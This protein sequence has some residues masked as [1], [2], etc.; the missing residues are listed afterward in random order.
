MF[1]LK[2][3]EGLSTS[4]AFAAL[5]ER[6]RS[7]LMCVAASMRSGSASLAGL[8][9]RFGDGAAEGAIDAALAGFLTIDGDEVRF[10]PE[11]VQRESSAGRVARLR[12]RRK[13][14]GSAPAA[15][16][17]RSEP[18][19]RQAQAL[20]SKI[21]LGAVFEAPAEPQSL[22][23]AFKAPA[24]PSP[25][26][27][28]SAEADSQWDDWGVEP[29]FEPEPSAISRPG[30]PQASAPI[31]AWRGLSG[32]GQATPEEMGLDL[33]LELDDD[34]EREAVEPPAPKAQ[35]QPQPIQAPAKLVREAQR[36]KAKARVQAL[37][38]DWME[39]EAIDEWLE[40]RALIGKKM[41]AL[42]IKK[43]VSKVTAYKAQGLDIGEMMSLAI[44]SGWATIYPPTG[45]KSDKAQAQR[46]GIK[47]T[48]GVAL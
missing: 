30:S 16:P 46:A 47:R 19:E 18:A 38:P 21:C 14:L 1:L 13:A 4:P 22:A 6:Q 23:I 31:G 25:A 39:Q 33:G 35:P 8:T 26:A 12:E 42:A 29:A 44:E 34:G 17:K 9:A 11:W 27:L 40:H 10:A 15:S 7:A 5:S 24:A 32:A 48:G 36:G 37:W 43:F 45:R 3:F 2:V 28:S 41:N 20:E